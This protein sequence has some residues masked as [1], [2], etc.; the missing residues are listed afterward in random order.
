[1]NPQRCLVCNSIIDFERAVKKHVKCCTPSC[2]VKWGNLHRDKRSEESRQKTSEGVKRFWK[3][4][5]GKALSKKRIIIRTCKLCGKEFIKKKGQHTSHKYCSTECAM[6]AIS[7]KRIDKIVKDGGSN[8]STKWNLNYNNIDYRCDSLL[9]AA[10]IIWLIN[11]MGASQ[12]NRSDLILEFIASDNKTHRYNPDFLAKIGEDT[13]I[14]EV[15]QD[16]NKTTKTNDWHRYSLFWDEKKKVLADYASE[17]GYKWL[18]LNPNY[19]KDF[20]KLYRKIQLD[21]SLYN[22]TKINRRID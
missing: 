5:E 2:V 1:M 11:S 18:W 15:K 17:Q 4:E 21:K 20:R 19:N 13:Y 14:I 9:E 3:T 22:L 8:F 16:W 12:I 6:S 7:K 10:A